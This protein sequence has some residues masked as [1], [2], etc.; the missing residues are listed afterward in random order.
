MKPLVSRALG[1]FLESGLS[2][3]V[4]TRDAARRPHGAAAWAVRVH[5]DGVHLTLFLHVD[6]AARLA[7]PL[8][9]CPQVAV[10]LDLPTTHRACQVKG[11]V[12][13]SRPA[14]DDE[15][16]VVERQLD[17]FSRDLEALGVPR[18][19]FA[20]WQA[21]PCTALVVQASALF[22]QTPGPGAGEPLVEAV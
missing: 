15:R 12:V 7:R 18:A 13:A 6:N 8:A 17:A 5:D 21:W 9:E 20:G 11:T 4:G 19:M 3:V 22:E 10:L 1:A 2:I 14:R 16:L